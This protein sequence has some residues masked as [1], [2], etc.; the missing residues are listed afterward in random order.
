MATTKAETTTPKEKVVVPSP[1]SPAAPAAAATTTSTKTATV[2][3]PPR[4]DVDERVKHPPFPYF[5]CA[6]TP[7][8]PSL[9][10]FLSQP[11]PPKIQGKLARALANPAQ[12]RAKK[13]RSVYQ[14]S[15][16]ASIP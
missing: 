8:V 14:T 15:E 6:R 9:T 10:L 4:H 5:F 16:T 13:A 1:P 11:L 2:V 12:R 7:A 3:E